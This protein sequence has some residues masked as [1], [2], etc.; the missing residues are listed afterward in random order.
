[1]RQL[2]SDTLHII[3]INHTQRNTLLGTALF[4]NICF[5]FSCPYYAWIN[6]NI[7]VIGYGSIDYENKKIFLETIIPDLSNNEKLFI[8][9]LINMNITGL[10]EKKIHKLSETFTNKLYQLFFEEQFITLN[11]VLCYD[12]EKLH[13]IITKW[14][15]I[16]TYCLLHIDLLKC[17]LS[18]KYIKKVYKTYKTNSIS[19]IKNNPYQMVESI[20][21]GF[22]TVDS[23]AEQYGIKRNH[24]LRIQQGLL[25][26]LQENELQ[27]HNYLDI[28]TLYEKLEILLSLT[29]HILF[30]TACNILIQEKKI[31]KLYQHYI[32]THAAYTYELYIY[33]YLKNNT[34]DN[35]LI[36][37]A[38]LKELSLQ[39]NKAISRAIEHKYS[40]ITGPAG[41]GKST[42]IK[43]LYHIQKNNKKRIVV[44]TPTGRASQR[45]KEID[46]N[47]HS[48]TIH[49]IL[50][51]LSIFKIQKGHTILP[52]EHLPYDHL[53]IDESS[54]IDSALLYVLL[55][56]TNQNTHITFL[57]DSFQ[58]P[59]IAMGS[60]F[61]DL[62]TYDYIPIFQLTEI[63]RQHKTSNLLSIAHAIAHG[64]YP[65]ISS[66]TTT[67]DCYFHVT[68]KD[69]IEEIIIN[70]I[71]MH[72]NGVTKTIDLQYITF[73]N[74][75]TAGVIKIN[76]FIQQY[77]FQHY[78]KDT[79]KIID[80]FYLYDKVMVIKN[81]YKIEVRNGEIGTII[82]GNDQEV[83]VQF[84]SEKIITFTYNQKYLLTLA[85]AINVYKS[86]GSEFN[87]IM[88]LLF[89]EQYLL[90]NKKALYTAVTRTKTQAILCGEKKALYCALNY[91]KSSERNTILS[92]FLK[93]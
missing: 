40:I 19:I 7:K 83:I 46:A 47:I 35:T 93:K 16:K 22:K 79:H 78:K 26:I 86:Q 41:T 57:G 18:A 69:N 2:F 24:P 72:Y 84:S 90:L 13:I 39:Q 51:P 23:I 27:G 3:S 74:R 75:G 34:I 33:E 76:T 60:P 65:K 48:M 82:D 5:L 58:L 8:S 91:K 59:P 53:I 66:K 21:F 68:T 49:K 29:D 85:Y 31:I 89:M 64:S 52:E 25:F 81:D 56:K 88:I 32:A 37:N 15:D 11:T 54:M 61:S 44:L 87:R 1:M 73:L 20:G 43:A 92:L 70:S 80:Q 50:T 6:T 10:T 28:T 4:Q 14:Q 36:H 77:L 12:E 67:S 71:K 62:I 30:D 9:F 45:L 42:I 63:F 17:G 55:K 38:T